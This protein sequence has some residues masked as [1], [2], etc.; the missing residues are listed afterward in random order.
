MTIANLIFPA[1][2]VFL[3][4]AIIQ[5]GHVP[6]FS[7]WLV[8][9]WCFVFPFLMTAF[10]VWMRRHRNK[11]ASETQSFTFSEDALF[12]EGGSFSVN[13]KWQAIHRIRETKQYFLFYISSFQAYFL[14]KNVLDSQ[15]TEYLRDL[16]HKIHK[17]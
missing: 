6:S 9:V 13:M 5:K 4:I 17:S 14:P 15:A 16:F 10:G 11:A 1:A 12:I 7:Q 8:A 3:L 2:G